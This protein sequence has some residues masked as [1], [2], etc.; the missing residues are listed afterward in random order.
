MAIILDSTAIE[1]HLGFLKDK[2]LVKFI[3][4]YPLGVLGGTVALAAHS[5]FG[6]SSRFQAPEIEPPRWAP[7]P[8][9]RLLQILSL[10]DLPARAIRS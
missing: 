8:A 7:Q 2:A 9:S 4:S 5:G 1:L 3:S 6:L 10:S